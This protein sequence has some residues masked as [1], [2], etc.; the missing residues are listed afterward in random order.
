MF[1][2]QDP[3]YAD[4]QIGDWTYGHPDVFAWGEGA[5]LKIGKFCSIAARVTI[6]LGGEHNTDWVTTYPFNPIF[7]QANAYTGH[8]KTKGNVTIGHD[9][10]L[11]IDSMVM[12]G[13]SIGN[14]AA[15]AA[16]STVTKDVPPYAI[17]GGNPAKVIRYRFPA[18]IIADLERIAWWNWPLPQVLSALPFLLS[19]QIE[20]FIQKYGK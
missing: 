17:V 10:W 12:S 8:P 18:S 11:G 7:P 5:A 20:P 3:R 19:N 2:N 4:Y 9:V 6:M 16:R 13:V 1:T 15:I 14:G